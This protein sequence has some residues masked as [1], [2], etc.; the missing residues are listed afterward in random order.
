MYNVIEYSDNYSKI[1]GS[2]WQ[3]HGNTIF[4]AIPSLNNNGNVVDF[5]GANYNSNSFKFKQKNK[6]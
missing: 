5:T 2:L 6:G 4:I 3:Y 1:P